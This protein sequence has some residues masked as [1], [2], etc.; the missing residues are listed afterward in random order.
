MAFGAKTSDAFVERFRKG[1]EAIK[2]NGSFEALK[3]KW[4]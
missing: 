3:R 4:L 2:K 1:L